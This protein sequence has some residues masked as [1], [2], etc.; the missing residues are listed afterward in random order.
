MKLTNFQLG[1]LPQTVELTGL[2][3][4]W[5]LHNFVDFDG[6]TVNEKEQTLQLRWKV[7]NSLENNEAWGDPSNSASGCSLLF[8]G[9]DIFT[10]SPK[11]VPKTESLTLHGIS[12]IAPGDLNQKEGFKIEW[13]EDEDFS[14]LFEFEG[15]FDIEVHSSL[16]ELKVL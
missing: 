4:Y 10:T 9:V 1:N 7:P 11:D 5:D 12:K 13:H 3:R 6:L 15:G 16:V 2:E 14:L 8:T